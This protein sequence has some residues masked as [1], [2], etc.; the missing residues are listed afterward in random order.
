[1]SKFINDLSLFESKEFKG[2]YLD[3]ASLYRMMMVE[4]KG[5]EYTLKKMSA[6]NP[7]LEMINYVNQFPVK[8]VDGENDK[9]FYDVQG[10]A[11]TGLVL[12]DIELADTGAMLSN[13]T[14]NSPITSNQEVFLYF[15]RPLASQTQIVKNPS[16]EFHF[17][18]KSEEKTASGTRYR[19]SVITEPGQYFNVPLDAVAMK[20]RWAVVSGAVAQHWSDKGMEVGHFA[21]SY[22]MMTMLAKMRYQY[23]VSGAM[24]DQGKNYTLKVPFA[25]VDPKTGKMVEVKSYV[26]ALDMAAIM[27]FELI[28]A[29]ALLYGKK[30]WDKWGNITNKD[31]NGYDIPTINGLFNQVAK[32]NK[33]KYNTFDLDYLT[34]VVM[35]RTIHKRSRN[36]R[37]VKLVTGSYGAIQFHKAVDAKV[38]SQNFTLT[39]G[40]FVNS[41][42]ASNTGSSNTLGFGHQ[43]TQYRA[44][45][46]IEFEIVIADWLDDRD[47]FGVAHPDN[48]HVNAESFTYYLT[49]GGNLGDTDAGIYRLK[50]NTNT[51]PA[52]GVIPGLRS[53]LSQGRSMSA[54]ASPRDGYECHY[55][56]A[57]GIVLADPDAIVELKLNV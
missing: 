11:S 28:K 6:I 18:I 46:G 14:L 34:D 49:A 54:I 42:S 3:E 41:A 10:E 38:G 8:M 31:E 13:G 21:G 20:G 24:I 15:E 35:Q 36:N 30:N 51:M 29:R 1:M 22:K 12:K 53:P 25:L 23:A 52:M 47:F 2:S 44:V 33:L 50:P 48:P 4:P 5:I 37:K 55:M 19:A 17:L 26:S 7:Q 27:E 45:N 16:D 43:Y 32:F 57:T 40:Q 56:D 9:F 39:S